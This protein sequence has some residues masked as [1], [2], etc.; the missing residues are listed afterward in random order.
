MHRPFHRPVRF[1][2]S[3]IAAVFTEVGQVMITANLPER[4]SP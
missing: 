2:I 3:Q 1:G 4:R